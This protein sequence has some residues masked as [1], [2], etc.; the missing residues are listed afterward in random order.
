MRVDR[1]G[2]ISRHVRSNVV[3]YIA[4]F[5]F[6]MGGTA[7]GTHPGGVN[8][9]SSEDIIDGNVKH[10]DLQIN[11]V[12]GPN[13]F[14]S[15]LSGADIQIDSLSSS[16][17][18]VGSVASSEVADGSL[19][20]AEFASSFPAV[21]ATRT[22]DQGVNNNT[23]TKLNF[24]SERY[25]TANMHTNSS[26]NFSRLTA[27]VTGIYEVTANI[28]WRD[29]GF[30]FGTNNVNLRRG[31]SVSAVIASSSNPGDLSNSVSTMVR[32]L[33]GDYVEVDVHQSGGDTEA[34]SS[35]SSVGQ[36][37][38]EFSMTWLAPGP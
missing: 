26:P 23:Q 5:L 7:Y 22:I 12:T 6:A 1:K 3:G 27:P 10:A 38:P 2:R 32:L 15:S 16:D 8:T 4:I 13:V 25:D 18:G 17:L 20:T 21:H 35:G 36:S 9:I 28:K 19:G 11:S 24:N 30:A 31:G 29:P 14:P 37:S 33:A 34:V